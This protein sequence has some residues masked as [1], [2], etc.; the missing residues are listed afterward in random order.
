MQIKQLMTAAC[1]LAAFVTVARA[2]ETYAPAIDPGAFSVTI[3]NPYFKMPV[4]K[5]MYFRSKTGE[6][7]ETTE[8]AITGKTRMIMGVET[9]EYWDRVYLEGVL[10]EETHDYI[11]QHKDGD[12]WYFGEDVDNYVDGKLKDHHGSWIAG[13]NGA[14][15]GIW[16]KAKPVVGETYR[17]EYYRG[18]AEDMAKIV[19]TTETV[20]TALGTYSD[21]VKT[22]NWTPLDPE[23]KEAKYYCK[24]VGGT[25][26]EL[27]VADDERDEL[28]KVEG[29][30]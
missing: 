12:V 1:V 6:G 7:L 2:A 27:N 14:L 20:K 9:L 17:E 24:D 5:K 10:I 28:I 25:V 29:S 3:D 11:A 30:S 16:V 19:S 8:I 22:E 23:V 4:G 26:L 15:P 21:C 18:E 13:E